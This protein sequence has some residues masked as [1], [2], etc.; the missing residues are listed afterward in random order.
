MLAQ[1]VLQVQTRETTEVRVRCDQGA[2]VL[3]RYCR[4]QRI[5]RQL[6][7][8]P[9][10]SAEIL[11]DRQVVRSGMDDTSVGSGDEL[12]NEVEDLVVG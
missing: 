10:T 4:V 3:H 1:R 6:G 9:G 2:A 5:G 7:G 8:C 11:E 12:S